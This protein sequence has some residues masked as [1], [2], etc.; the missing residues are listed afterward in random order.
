MNAVRIIGEPAALELLAEEA[1]ELA[2]AALKLAR[3]LRGEN[4]TPVS[5]LDAAAQFAEELG[6]VRLCTRALEEYYGKLDT[7]ETEQAKSRRWEARLQAFM[8]E[9]EAQRIE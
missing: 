7:T 5:Y 1:V 3:V 6:D 8:K 2:H 9:K 4:P